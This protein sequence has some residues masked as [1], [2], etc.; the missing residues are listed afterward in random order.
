MARILR[1]AESYQSFLWKPQKFL[2]G[3]LNA[4]IGQIDLA[5]SPEINRTI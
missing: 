2:L 4:D 1:N 3:F 5:V